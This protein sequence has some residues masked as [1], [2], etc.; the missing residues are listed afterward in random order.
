M[1]YIIHGHRLV[2]VTVVDR[3]CMSLIAVELENGEVVFVKKQ[4]ISETKKLTNAM[5]ELVRIRIERYK[6]LLKGYRKMLKGGE[7]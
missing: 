4:F 6:N 5:E 3:E 2:E 1:S 7:K